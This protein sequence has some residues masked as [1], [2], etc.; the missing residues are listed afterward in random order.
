MKPP[1]SSPSPPPAAE[2]ELLTQIPPSE[3]P[4][5]SQPWGAGQRASSTLAANLTAGPGRDRHLRAMLRGAAGAA[6]E[7]RTRVPTAAAGQAGPTKDP[8][9]VQ[10]AQGA[11]AAEPEPLHRV[12]ATAAPPARQRPRPL[13]PG[14]AHIHS[15]I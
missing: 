9:R 3:E 7:G 8:A 11:G 5:S 4:R 2:A 15:R 10:K 12:P 1:R 14:Y 6:G 13:L